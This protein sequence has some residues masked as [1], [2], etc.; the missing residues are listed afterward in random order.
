ML[1]FTPILQ[2]HLMLKRL[3][4]KNRA[5]LCD[6]S[7]FSLVQVTSWRL[8]RFT[9][10]NMLKVSFWMLPVDLAGLCWAELLLLD[11]SWRVP[12]CRYLEGCL[13]MLQNSILTLKVPIW[14]LM[15]KTDDVMGPGMTWILIT[16][17]MGQTD[18]L[19]IEVWTQ[20]IY[21]QLS[22]QFSAQNFAKYLSH[23]DH[24]K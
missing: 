23:H 2:Q 7:N 15:D 16:S 17:N 11:S 20:D 24:Y 3:Q 1:W 10:G 14:S 5:S 21:I 19:W 4:R 8:L 6:I 22:V 13:L 12:A 18:L 9:T